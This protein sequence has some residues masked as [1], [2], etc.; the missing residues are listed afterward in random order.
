[1]TKNLKFVT[2]VGLLFLISCGSQKDSEQ[3]SSVE[4][5][6]Y[7]SSDSKYNYTYY[8]IVT[9]LL[10]HKGRNN[11]AVNIFTS[12]INYFD[13]E[14][15]FMSMIN[16]ARELNKFDSIMTIV[17]RWLE[18]DDQNIYA[19]KTAFSVYIELKQ[20]QLA[21]THFDFLYD[22]YLENKNES[23]ID[24]ESILSRNIIIKN[25]VDYFE[26]NLPRYN[27][28]SILLSY[29]NILQKNELDELVI[30][31]I[32]DIEF[33]K[34]R[35][36]TRKYAKSLSKLNETHK[37]IT[38][39]ESFIKSSSVL[40]R[41]VSFE[42]LSYYLKKEKLDDSKSLIE[43]LINIDP[44]DDDFIFRI[45]LLCFDNEKYSLSE[46]YFNILLSKS[47]SSDNI[48]FFLGQID[49]KNRS[50]DEALLHYSRIQ[51]GTFINIKT[52]NVS[53]ALLKKY[54]LEKALIY[55]DEN[56]QIKNQ[57]DQLNSL[58]L[59]LSVFEEIGKTIDTINLSSEI[60]ELFPNNERALYARALA[61]EKQGDIFNMSKDFDKMI[62][63]NPYNSLALNAYG[64]S[65]SL[66]KVHLD[67]A[68]TMIRKALAINPGQAA[69]LDSLAWVLFLKGSYI[70]AAEYSSLAYSKDQD[71]EIVEHYYKIL[72]KNGNFDE[73]KYILE[74]SIKKYPSSKKLLNLLDNN[75]NAA[76]NL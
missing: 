27:A 35:I 17:N 56:I 32:K 11:D 29:I 64:Y 34:N 7:K 18:I 2:V 65:L 39:L 43:K 69:I 72:L 41:E 1:M 20:Y 63:L 31:Y 19:H 15:D 6:S 71:P 21:S 67:R 3:I 66:H 58:S 57:D 49:Y 48:N 47:Y 62:S 13:S 68:E 53:M 51:Q 33:K 24:I 76:I 25:V 45:A 46:K 60:L 55:I 36:L 37:A 42:L 50:Y 74:Q 4:N 61:Y 8:K 54:D 12:N 44:S 52:F 22:R 38:T 10:L 26:T 73:A 59:K 5:I 30:K 40:D 70:D 23:Y 28:Q 9:E 14:A 75:K 16:R